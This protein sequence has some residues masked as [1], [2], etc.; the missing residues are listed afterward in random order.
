MSENTALIGTTNNSQVIAVV[1]PNVYDLVFN[2]YIYEWNLP[3]LHRKD[4]AYDPEDIEYAVDILTHWCATAFEKGYLISIW[5]EIAV[6]A[7]DHTS[8]YLFV[9]EGASSPAENH[10]IREFMDG[11]KMVFTKKEVDF[12]YSYTNLECINAKTDLYYYVKRKQVSVFN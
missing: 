3:I 4:G 1:K 9:G 8:V 10:P 12:L 6:I 5:K 2:G 11:M 7:E